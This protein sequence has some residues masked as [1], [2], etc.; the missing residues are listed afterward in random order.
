MRFSKEVFPVFPF[1]FLSLFSLVF[2][3]AGFESF[4][5]SLPSFPSFLAGSSETERISLYTKL[6]FENLFL[7]PVLNY[8]GINLLNSVDTLNSHIFV[9]P[10]NV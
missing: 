9:G 8:S 6:E 10:K 1:A 7:F 2:G 3:V 4:S 5:I